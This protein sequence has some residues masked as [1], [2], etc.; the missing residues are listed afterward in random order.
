MEKAASLNPNHPKWY[1]YSLSYASYQQRDY[2]TAAA[3]AEKGDLPG[4]FWTWVYR[5]ASYSQSGQKERAQAAARELLNLYPDFANQW[6]EEYRKWNF[7]DHMAAHLA[8]GFEKA[9]L[10]IP[11]EPTATD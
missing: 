8:E 6:S 11:D 1:F 10:D 5:T 9:G 3:Y 4:F 2:E 7:P